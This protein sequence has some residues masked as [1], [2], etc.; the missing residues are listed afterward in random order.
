MGG[1][2]GSCEITTNRINLDLI[3]H[4]FNSRRNNRKRVLTTRE[5]AFLSHVML[6]SWRAD[7]KLSWK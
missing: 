2:A 1:L 5:W 6:L 7:F 3:F 4:V